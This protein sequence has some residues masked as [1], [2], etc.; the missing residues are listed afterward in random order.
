[1][2]RE[3]Y[4]ITNSIINAIKVTSSMFQTKGEEDEYTEAEIKEIAEYIKS[5]CSQM[6]IDDLAV[7]LKYCLDD[8][9]KT[10]S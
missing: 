6:M 8:E 4:A 9:Q 1:M 5:Q 7:V 10:T 2:N 3:K